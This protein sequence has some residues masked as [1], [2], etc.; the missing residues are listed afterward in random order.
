[1]GRR[2]A[3][4]ADK[5]RPYNKAD[6]DYDVGD[7]EYLT[8]DFVPIDPEGDKSDRSGTSGNGQRTSG[9]GQRTSGNANATGNANANNKRRKFRLQTQ[10]DAQSSPENEK[11]PTSRTS[12]YET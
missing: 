1:L 2:F 12:R 3:N 6:L 11:K 10:G 9:N 4:A 7:R 5:M 8:I